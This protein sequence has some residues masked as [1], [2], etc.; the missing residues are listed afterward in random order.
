MYEGWHGI[1]GMECRSLNYL[2]T[3]TNI[4]GH[5]LQDSHNILLCLCCTYVPAADGPLRLLPCCPV[6]EKKTNCDWSAAPHCI[7]YFLSIFTLSR[8]WGRTNMRN[9][10]LAVIVVLQTVA[11]LPAKDNAVSVLQ[12]QE[13]RKWTWFNR[14]KIFKKLESIVS[15]CPQD[16]RAAR[17]PRQSSSPSSASGIDTRGDCLFGSGDDLDLCEW[18]NV[19]FSAFEWLPSNGKDSFWIGGPRKDSNA[20]NELGERLTTFIAAVL[21]EM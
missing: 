16:E 6:N 7:M 15:V 4:V 20:K 2:T 19:P 21:L 14:G 17:R 12:L 1:C 10:G 8:L 11:A 13:S 9:L 5:G 3:S 18:A